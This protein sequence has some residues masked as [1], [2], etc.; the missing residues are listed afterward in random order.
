MNEKKLIKITIFIVGIFKESRYWDVVAE[1]AK[2]SPN[3]LLINIT[4]TNQGPDP[5]KL[6]VLPTLWFR[7]TWI[8]GCKHEGCT[9][10][11]KIKEIATNTVECW[12]ETLGKFVFMADV[13]QDGKPVE[14]LF[15][16]NETNSEVCITYFQPCY[17]VLLFVPIFFFTFNN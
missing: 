14:M 1:Y 15:T 16:E 4:I 12:H 6:H 11:S 5:V 17:V 3:D 7:N 10:K 8:W 13:G 2:S 9:Q